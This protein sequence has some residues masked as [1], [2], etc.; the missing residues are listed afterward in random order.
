MH[1]PVRHRASAAPAAPLA[2]SVCHLDLSF[3]LSHLVK[4][5]SLPIETQRPLFDD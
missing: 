3:F 4:S 1:D 2:L 5:T